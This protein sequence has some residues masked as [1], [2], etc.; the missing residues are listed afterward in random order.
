MSREVN[1]FVSG[2]LIVCFGGCQR[3][4]VIRTGLP[5]LREFLGTVVV[6]S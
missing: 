5:D 3:D 1:D 2:M 6:V 4:G